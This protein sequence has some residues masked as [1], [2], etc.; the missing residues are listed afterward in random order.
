MSIILD[1]SIRMTFH[2]TVKSYD[3]RGGIKDPN[4]YQFR[5]EP[6]L[7]VKS[8]RRSKVVVVCKLPSID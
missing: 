5:Y 2:P 7:Y 6:I 8:E 4:T 3:F 1:Q